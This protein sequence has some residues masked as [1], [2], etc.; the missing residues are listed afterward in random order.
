MNFDLPLADLF[1]S[2]CESSCAAA[3]SVY[4]P[5]AAGTNVVAK[6][7]TA[8]LLCVHEKIHAYIDAKNTCVC[9]YMHSHAYTLTQACTHIL[10]LSL[11]FAL[12]STL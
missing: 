3:V 2:A 6:T 12:T 4:K 11:S 10:Y 9:V 5:T 8:I 1:L 7:L